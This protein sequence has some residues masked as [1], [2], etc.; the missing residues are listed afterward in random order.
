[1]L[2]DGDGV[3]PDACALDPTAVAA[4]PFEVA[5][6]PA[7]REPAPVAPLFVLFPPGVPPSSTL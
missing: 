3:S 1:M 7:A 2:A 6:V 5:S 4:S